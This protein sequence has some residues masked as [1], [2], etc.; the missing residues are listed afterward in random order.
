ML[1]ATVNPSS[2]TVSY[3]WQRAESSD[4]E[5]KNIQ[6]ATARTYTLTDDDAN[7]YVKVIATGSGS[8]TGTVSNSTSEPVKQITYTVTFKDW[9]DTVLDT[10]T[11]EK[12]K[13]A[14][15]PTVPGR[16]GYV[17][18]NWN[19]LF[20]NVT[21][22]LI[23][24][25]LYEI[26]KYTLSFDSNSG[27][28]VDSIRNIEH[29]S[30]VTL[31]ANPT[32]EGL[33]FAGWFVDNNVFNIAFTESTVVT[34]NLTVYA[35]WVTEL[36][37]I[38]GVSLN[39][40]VTAILPGATEQL[41]ATALPANADNKAV[42]WRSDDDSIASVDSEGLVTG[43]SVGKTTI[44]ATTVDGNKIAQ[45]TIVVY[46]NSVEKDFEFDAYNKLITGYKGNGGNV[47]ISR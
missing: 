27:S 23:V 39:K 38:A 12:G 8:Y 26:N 24:T 4:G 28:L 17:F 14:V 19:I 46:T 22:D 45:C 1:T 29:N 15:A 6:G 16:E 30:T 11:V 47:T 21:R 35:K 40:K 9:N 32:K 34:S 25:A 18:I 37:P 13:D 36:I 43:H 33:H 20:N 10:Q 7:K 41:T 44:T 5:Y 2:A 42:T 3:R 31:P